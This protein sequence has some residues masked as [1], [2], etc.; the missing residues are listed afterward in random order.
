MADTATD[1]NYVPCGRPLGMAFDTLGDFLIVMHS[2]LGIFEV[3]LKT[4]QKNNLVDADKVIGVKV[5]ADARKP[6][7]KILFFRNFLESP[8]M[9]TF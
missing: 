3:D 7:G 1:D 2:S 6:F 4:G 8:E 9:Q 5:N